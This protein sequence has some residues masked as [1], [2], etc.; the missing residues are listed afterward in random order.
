MPYAYGPWMPSHS[1][2]GC[3]PRHQLTQQLKAVVLRNVFEDGQALH[4]LFDWKD[5]DKSSATGAAVLH[6]AGYRLLALLAFEV[7][8][9]KREGETGDNDRQ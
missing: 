6:V 1:L 5:V 2:V 9:C 3:E 8:A 4:V 7:L